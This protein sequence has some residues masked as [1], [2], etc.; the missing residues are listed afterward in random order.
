MA[1]DP[2][3]LSHLQ[4]GTTNVA[5][6]WEVIRTDGVRLGFTD[7]DQ[8]L[9]FDGLVFSAE[10][11]L[12]ARVV[13]K[14]T[15]L[16]VDNGE[17]IG[18]LSSDAIREADIRAGRF[19]A[20]E[21]KSWIVNWSNVSERHLIFRGTIGEIIRSDGQ[22]QAELRGISE[23]LNVPRGR[24]YQ[25]ACSAVLGDENCKFNLN[26]SGFYAEVSIQEVVDAKTLKFPLLNEFSDTWF[27]R[28][29]L[30][31]LTGEATG[32]VR[33]IKTDVSF[34]NF[35]RQVSVRLSQPA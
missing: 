18:A 23:A 22:F 15:G 14:T 3:F 17:A 30:E 24:V 1:F 28:G 11:G 2:D 31:V 35:S 8:D 34:A 12:S 21:V 32:L 19:D 25:S 26:T 9:Y 29:W 20:A 16:S 6:A 27:E 10:A 33:I 4:S 13:A 7:H 5:R